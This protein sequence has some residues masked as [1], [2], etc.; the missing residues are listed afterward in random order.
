MECTEQNSYCN[1][2]QIKKIVS[3]VRKS[4]T[5]HGEFIQMAKI[6]DVKPLQ[7]IQDV[8]VRWNSTYLMLQ[9]VI[10]MRKVSP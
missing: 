9:R 4:S 3:K 1:F 7:L 8:S 6:V 2:F 5:F 10:E